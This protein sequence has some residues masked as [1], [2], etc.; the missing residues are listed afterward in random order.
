MRVT[1]EGVD[2]DGEGGGGEAGNTTH[3]DGS[4]TERLTIWH[5]ASYGGWSGNAYNTVIPIRSLSKMPIVVALLAL[6]ETGRYMRLSLDAR[7]GD[8]FGCGQLNAVRIRELL[9]MQAL[10]NRLRTFRKAQ[11]DTAER[12]GAFAA[13]SDHVGFPHICELKRLSV[14]ECVTQAICPAY[15]ADV[16]VKQAV[17]STQCLNLDAT[18]TVPGDATDQQTNRAA[19][20]AAAYALP[21]S[22]VYDN[23]GYTLVD[24]I[25]QQET[26]RDLK[27]WMRVLVFEPLDMNVTLACLYPEE[28]GASSEYGAY[29][30]WVNVA[31]TLRRHKVHSLVHNVRAHR[32]TR[33]RVRW[34]GPPSATTMQPSEWPGGF[35][36]PSW[37]SVSLLST[38]YEFTRFMLMLLNRGTLG[39][40]RILS[41][42]HVHEMMRA[43]NPK[44]VWT[45]LGFFG[46]GVMHD[47]R[48]R[49]G[50]HGWASAYGARSSMLL[51]HGIVCTSFH[52]VDNNLRSSGG[53]RVSDR[54][55]YMW[56]D[57]TAAMR[58]ACPRYAAA[59]DFKRGSRAHTF[60]PLTRGERLAEAQRR[61][62]HKRRQQQQREIQLEQMRNNKKKRQQQ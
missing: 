59:C 29:R 14:L 40:R 37:I 38:P 36:G 21:A 19:S 51:D 55:Y 62:A 7:V 53:A 20:G 10:D 54:Y 50:V 58:S 12:S 39:G 24:A 42:A 32:R 47:N 57:L 33:S 61:A 41:E 52:N 31:R 60:L 1:H 45:T 25:V 18:F 9:S 5:D 16:S 48:H 46:L 26:G 6:I 28:R 49:W 34:E 22:W 3:T 30:S 27:H 35:L 11:T 13:P 4:S 8:F 44:R 23:Y 15:R 43:Q 2:E 56:D 17:D